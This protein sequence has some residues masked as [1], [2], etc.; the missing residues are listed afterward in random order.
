MT[1]EPKVRDMLS[2][3][4]HNMSE[5]KRKRAVKMLE[6]QKSPERRKSPR[7]KGQMPV[8]WATPEV[9]HTQTL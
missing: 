6:A 7:T 5:D 2:K 3:L 1:K 9:G 4:V 8:D